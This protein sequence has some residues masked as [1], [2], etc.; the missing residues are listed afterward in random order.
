[1]LKFLARVITGEKMKSNIFAYIMIISFLCAPAYSQFEEFAAKYDILTTIAGKGELDNGMSG[2][3]DEYE[4]GLATQAEL[5][6]PHF[7]MADSSGNIYI[8]DKESHAIRK[9]TTDG[10]ITTVAGTNTA[11]DNGDGLATETQLSSP[12][13]IWVKPDGTFFIL[14][15]GNNKIRKVDKNGYLTTIVD[16]PSG[17]AIGR[18]LWVSQNEEEIYYVSGTRIKKW[19]K[20][21][22][23]VTYVSGFRQPGNIIVDPSGYLVV[24]DRGADLVY[25][26]IHD[27]TK[28]VIAGNGLATG[29]GNGFQA[30]ETGLDGVRGIWFM[31]DGSYLLATHEGSQIWYV[32]PSGIINLLL[33]GKDGDEYHS[34]DGEPFQ[35]PG[36][37]ISEARSVSMDYNGNILITENDF[38]FI[39]KIAKKHT[40]S[41]NMSERRPEKIDLQVYPNPFNP[42]TEIQYDIQHSTHVSIKIYNV[43]GSPI[44]TLVDKVEMAGYHV[45]TWDGK[46]D[47][48]HVVA[49][50]IY[51]C[52][53]RAGSLI[54]TEKLL[55]VR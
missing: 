29:G 36:Y 20:G 21:E 25:R 53:M 19:V 7:A 41:I 51:F 17:I 26:I 1:M 9:V 8:A 10:I 44:R 4:G 46:D 5:S 35:S 3:L 47:N 37:K 11:G 52:L 15:L 40:T 32:D 33:D 13:G 31:E 55:F 28:V 49:S 54:D 6:R 38:G 45:V 27:T 50:G 43:L 14:D 42:Q 18:G 16:D 24:T 12:N 39:R 2:W 48:Q 30:T 34:G 23:I 22:G